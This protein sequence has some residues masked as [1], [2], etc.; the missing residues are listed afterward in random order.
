[1]EI[2]NSIADAVGNTPLVRLDRLNGDGYHNLL[3]KCEFMNPGGSVKDRIA[4]YMVEQAEKEGALKPGQLIVEAT[5]GNT[6]IGLALA[7]KLTGHK[8]LTVMTDKVGKDKV[9]LMQVLGAET[10]VVPRGKL[11]DDPEHFINIARRIANEKNGWYVSQFDNKHNLD[12]H[13]KFT[14]PELWRQT[15]GTIDALV[16]GIG[17]GGT[18]CGAGRFLK[19]MKPSI[20]LVL[21]DP[22]GSLLANWHNKQEP[23]PG[24]YLVE[25]IGG[26]F[27]AGNVSMEMIDAA[28]HI[29]DRTSFATAHQLLEKEGIFAG[30]SSGC[31]VAAALRF[32][33]ENKDEKLTIV[34]VL[35]DTGRLY[36]D[37][38]FNGD[39]LKAQLASVK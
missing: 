15:D 39:W 36:M 24:A 5:G 4:F 17:T 35:P 27:V 6:G 25:G 23:Q 18:L 33:E 16:A 32:G 28:V 37:T 1:M 7:A 34:A 12:A 38:M 26:D 30:S 9:N 19:E 8:L 14:G 31:V 10:I 22:M 13:Y 20:K 2:L 3:G 11:I 21:A 29:D